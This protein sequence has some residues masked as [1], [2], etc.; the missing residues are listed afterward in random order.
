[1]PSISNSHVNPLKTRR[2]MQN[3]RPNGRRR[4]GRLLKILL[5]KAETGLLRPNS[6]RLMMMIMMFKMFLLRGVSREHRK[7]V[8]LVTFLSLSFR[9]AGIYNEI[10]FCKNA[11]AEGLDTCCIPKR[12]LPRVM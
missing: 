1:V 5:D 3:Y 4:F 7:Q 11:L 9:N 10:H 2:L 8:K 6:W 12:S